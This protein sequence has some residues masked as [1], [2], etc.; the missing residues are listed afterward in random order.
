MRAPA[1]EV[2]PVSIIDKPPSA[3]LRP[4]QRDDDSLPPYDVLDGI[5][6]ML[7]DREA[8]V[9]EC[10]LFEEVPSEYLFCGVHS[11]FLQFSLIWAMM[12]AG[13]LSVPGSSWI[14]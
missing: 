8:S 13:M 5:L 14:R 10:V 3:E 7:V 9:A 6:E 2:I 4:D 11:G 12:V 1:G